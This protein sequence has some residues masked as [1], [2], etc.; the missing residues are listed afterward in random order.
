MIKKLIITYLL[1]FV[2]ILNSF[3]L[4][5]NKALAELEE[6]S[7]DEAYKYYVLDRIDAAD[8]PD[9]VKKFAYENDCFKIMKH[10]YWSDE[11]FKNKGGV[12][13]C[14]KDKKVQYIYDYDNKLR[15]AKWYEKR[16]FKKPVFGD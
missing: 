11:L 4:F 3:P 2:F 12:Y 6:M 16:K 8:S 15:F 10:Y 1:F 7:G 14:I 13:S 5:S 9:Y